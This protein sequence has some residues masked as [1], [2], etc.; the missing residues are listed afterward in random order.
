MVYILM[1]KVTGWSIWS[2]VYYIDIQGD[3]LE[4]AELAVD[5]I[6]GT[7]GGPGDQQIAA[8]IER[9]ILAGDSLAESTRNKEDFTRARYIPVYVNLCT[10]IL[11][12]DSLAE[13]GSR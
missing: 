1:Y 2:P 11:A 10:D 8:Q 4:A 7:A 6:C 5:W 12:G 3:W 13:S 9:V